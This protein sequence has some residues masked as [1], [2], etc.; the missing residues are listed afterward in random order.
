MFIQAGVTFTVTEIQ[1][2]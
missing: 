2:R 1:A